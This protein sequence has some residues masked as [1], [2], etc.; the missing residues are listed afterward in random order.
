MTTK[1]EAR[2]V[3]LRPD[4]DPFKDP[5]AYA[6]SM[7]WAVRVVYTLDDGTELPG[8]MRS[9]SRKR[10][11]FESAAARDGI[12]N[13]TATFVDGTFFGTSTTYRLGG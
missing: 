13:M 11:A 9:F 6:K 8:T 5:N 2:I 1:T 4:G 7:P 12:T 3:A 10:D